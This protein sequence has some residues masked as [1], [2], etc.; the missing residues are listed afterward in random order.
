MADIPVQGTILV[1]GSVPLNLFGIAQEAQ[2]VVVEDVANYLSGYPCPQPCAKAQYARA[3]P[4][5]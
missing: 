5:H 2:G 4:T 3:T 1:S